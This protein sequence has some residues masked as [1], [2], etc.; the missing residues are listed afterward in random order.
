MLSARARSEGHSRR[1]VPRRAFQAGAIPR[2]KMCCRSPKRRKQTRH[3]PPAMR[4]QLADLGLIKASTPEVPMGSPRSTPLVA[5]LSAAPVPLLGR[6]AQERARGRP[7]RARIGA[8]ESAS[9][10]R[11]KPSQLMQGGGRRELEVC[12]PENHDLSHAPCPPCTGT[13]ATLSSARGS[14]DCSASPP[15]RW[16][17]ISTRTVVTSDGA[18]RPSTS[19]WPGHGGRLVPRALSLTTA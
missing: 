2:P 9:V 6:E 15:A 19:T 5:G 17:W 10:P 18:I 1:P 11:R 13:R 8:N 3:M 16:R 14:M 4:R 7:F 12:H